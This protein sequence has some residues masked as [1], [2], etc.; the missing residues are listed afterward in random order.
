MLPWQTFSIQEKTVACIFALQGED[1]IKEC[2]KILGSNSSFLLILQFKIAHPK[3]MTYVAQ[4]SQA[5][6][7]HGRSRSLLNFS[8]AQCQLIDTD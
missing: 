2:H 1:G 6:I 5:V 4:G 7:E 8:T 3:F